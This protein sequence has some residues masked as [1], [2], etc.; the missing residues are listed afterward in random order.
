MQRPRGTGPRAASSSRRDA[1]PLLGA[2]RS[3]VVR[4]ML[5]RRGRRSFLE[6]VRNVVYPPGGW[7]RAARYIY[8]RL[9][10][11]PD[12]PQRIAR[13]VFA[14]TLVGFTPFFGLHFLIAPAIAAAIRGNVVASL[15]SVF[16]CNPLTFP[17]IAAASVATGR[18]ITGDIASI[19]ET[20]RTYLVLKDGLS[21]TWHNLGAQFT[22]KHA[23]WEPVLEIYHGVFIPYLTGGVLLGLIAGLLAAWLSGKAVVVYQKR[24]RERLEKRRR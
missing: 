14:G 2:L 10:R 17:V 20:R 24:R 18:L 23:D 12:S 8:Y 13:G 11:I 3:S 7:K 9:R 22:A 5:G 4:S 1:L 6:S 21:Q 19:E 15:L 16:V